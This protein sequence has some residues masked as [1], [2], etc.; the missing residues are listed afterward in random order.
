MR[1]DKKPP[2]IYRTGQNAKQ[3]YD[4]YNAPSEPASFHS[5]LRTLVLLLSAV[6]PVENIVPF[7]STLKLLKST[8]LVSIFAYSRA[9]LIEA[10]F[11]AY[12]LL[13]DD[14]L[15]GFKPSGT[16]TPDKHPA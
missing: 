9:S 8:L 16:I 5:F 6:L 4:E 11:F 13:F 14:V 10:T 12:S 15:F 3:F 1:Y 7:S 2:G